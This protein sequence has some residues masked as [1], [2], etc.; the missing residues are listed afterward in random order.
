MR[1]RPMVSA[2]HAAAGSA[3]NKRRESAIRLDRNTPQSAAN[4]RREINRASFMARP[5]NQSSQRLLLLRESPNT[6]PRDRWLI[7]LRLVPATKSSR[8]LLV[9]QGDH[10]IDA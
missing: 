7:L 2:K 1:P 4:T 5:G 8:R 10:G 3:R 9:A 6:S